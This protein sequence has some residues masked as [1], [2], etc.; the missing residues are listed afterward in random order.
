[1]RGFEADIE[2]FNRLYAGAWHLRAGDVDEVLAHQ[3]VGQMMCSL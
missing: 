3:R 2:K 1:M